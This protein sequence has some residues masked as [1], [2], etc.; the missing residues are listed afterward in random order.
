[1]LI[2]Y[3]PNIPIE[4]N[5]IPSALIVNILYANK[6]LTDSLFVRLA[7]KNKPPNNIHIAVHKMLKNIANF[8]GR[9]EN[10]KIISDASLSLF[11]KVYDGFPSNLEP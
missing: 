7:I 4:L 8:N 2:K 10:A 5:I 3:T 6:M 11:F 1:M 9:S